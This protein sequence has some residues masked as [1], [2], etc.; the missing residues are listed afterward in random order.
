MTLRSSSTTALTF[1]CKAPKDAFI[2]GERERE[3]EKGESGKRT[4]LAV[5][6][7]AD[8]SEWD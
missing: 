3:R 2:G 6:P 1:T 5:P 4:R 8:P 7:A